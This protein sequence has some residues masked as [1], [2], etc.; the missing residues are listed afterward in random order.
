[1]ILKSFELNKINLKINKFILFYG[2]NEG[3]KNQ[4]IKNLNKSYSTIL[5]Y[6]QNEIIENS[7]EILDTFFTRSL[8][9]KEK[10]VIINRAT[11]KICEL[12]DQISNRNTGENVFIIN[13][14]SLE[15]K[16]KLRKY[17]EKSSTNIC[18]PFYPDTIET[19]SKIA[20]QTLKNKNIAISSSNLNLII[21]KCG[22]DR[23]VLIKELEKI[24]CYANNRK[25]IDTEVILKLTNLIENHSISDLV[26]NCLAKN[27]KKTINI[28]LENNFSSEDCILITRIFLNKLKRILNLCEKFEKN[29][30]LEL[31][32]SAAKPPIF[33]KEKEITKQQILNW[34]PKKI[35]ESLY[36]VNE[37]ELSIKKNY[38]NSINLITNFILNLASNQ[39]NN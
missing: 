19:L 33:W 2:K 26:D 18:I 4:E 25:K 36:N 32:V 37:I 39:S 15:K 13:A 9:E 38:D 34:T 23:E 14:D 22:G 17:F 11:D 3:Y 30:N 21:S 24:T 6:D 12:I 10:F 31:T 5:S 27:K 1:M 20:S 29:K 7:S 8:F 16:S 35:K 28:L